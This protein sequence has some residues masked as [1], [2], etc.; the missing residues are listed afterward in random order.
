MSNVR[1]GG[2]IPLAGEPDVLPFLAKLSDSD[3]GMGLRVGFPAMCGSDM[4]FLA[5]NPSEIN[6]YD[7][8]HCLTQKGLDGFNPDVLL[9]PMVGFTLAGYRLGRGKGMYDRYLTAHP[10]VKSI[11]VGFSWQLV[12]FQPEAHDTPLSTIVTEKTVMSFSG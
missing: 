11:G 5:C 9:V 8:Y 4:A 2:F 7:R 12:D 3:G 1:V 10:H 6:G